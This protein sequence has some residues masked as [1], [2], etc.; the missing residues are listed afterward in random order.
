MTVAI[1]T[2]RY[3]NNHQTPSL[4]KYDSAPSLPSITVCVSLSRSLSL[5]V[6]LNICVTVARDRLSRTA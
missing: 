4:D 5:S 3:G 2:T 1:N 6:S